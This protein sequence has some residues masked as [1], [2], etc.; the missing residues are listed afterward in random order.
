MSE[1]Y[2]HQGDYPHALAYMDNYEKL[3][4]PMGR[5]E[6]YL[7]G[8][9]YYADREYDRAVERLSQVASGSDALAQNACFHLADCYLQTGDRAKAMSAFGLASAADYDP[10]IKE[11]AMFDYGKLQY[12]QG[13]GVFDGAIAVLNNYIESFP[14]SPRVGEARELLLAAYFNSRNYDAA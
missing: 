6:L 14:S 12:E 2:F 13:G 4:G 9:C 5:E 8:Y 10:E 3:G 11:E 1:A 7:A